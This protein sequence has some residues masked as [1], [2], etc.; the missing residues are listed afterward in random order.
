MARKGEE[1]LSPPPDNLRYPRVQTTHH[2]VRYGET[3]RMGV[4]LSLIHI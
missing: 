1:F 3:D 4:V 2:R